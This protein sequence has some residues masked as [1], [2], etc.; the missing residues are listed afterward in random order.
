MCRGVHI[1]LGGI[2]MK[3]LTNYFTKGEIALWLCSVTLILVSFAVFGTDGPLVPI[4]SL[5]GVTSLI[6]CA[7]GHPA[8]QGLMI[9][10]SLIYG[11]ISYNF[12]YYGEMLTYVGMTM[13]MAVVSMIS[14]LRNPYRGNRSEV[15]VNHLRKK[16]YLAMALLSLAVTV[17]F[18]F[19]LKYFNTANLLPSTISVTTSFAAVYLTA[20]RSHC[21]ALAYAA[22]DIILII[23]WSMAS[24]SDVSYVSVTVC[25]A[26][27][28]VNDLYGFINWTKMAKRQADAP[29][30]DIDNLPE[31]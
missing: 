13:P 3:K 31:K 11:I 2:K 23:L 24:L 29:Y 12:T 28:L 16:E 19:I 5:V 25:F 6:F 17:L 8:G 30:I 1:F 18:Y 27:F 22:N 26:A 21:Y 10:F 14:W 20:R 9:L 15:R 7:K 4:A